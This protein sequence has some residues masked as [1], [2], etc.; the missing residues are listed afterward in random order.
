M[1]IFNE[2]LLWNSEIRKLASFCDVL[3]WKKVR[4]IVIFDQT[5]A[6]SLKLY[7]IKCFNPICVLFLRFFDWSVQ[8]RVTIIRHTWFQGLFLI[9]ISIDITMKIM[10]YERFSAD[11]TLW[12]I[13]QVCMIWAFG[14]FNAL[15]WIFS[16]NWQNITISLSIFLF[17][18]LYVF[19]NVVLLF[20]NF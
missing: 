18:F 16:I 6:Y 20:R 3:D 15:R 5:S 7:S 14:I 19:F 8:F 11:F 1:P 10:N 9:L 4:E 2:N 13:R 12:G 17:T